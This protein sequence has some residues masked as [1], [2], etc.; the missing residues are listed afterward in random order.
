VAELASIRKKHIE[1]G[2]LPPPLPLPKLSPRIEE[3]YPA[4]TALEELHLPPP[5]LPSER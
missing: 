1:A 4:R 5:S 2:V 3:A